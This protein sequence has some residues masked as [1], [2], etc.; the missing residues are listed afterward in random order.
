MSHTASSSTA[1]LRIGSGIIVPIDILTNRG[2][3]SLI[4]KRVNTGNEMK[5][6]S[7]LLV[8]ISFIVPLAFDQVARPPIDYK[9][10]ILNQDQVYEINPKKNLFQ[11]EQTYTL[12]NAGSENTRKIVFGV[13]P[14]L[15][16]QAIILKNSEGGILPH[17]VVKTSASDFRLG[18]RF[19]VYELE[20][21]TDIAPRQVLNFHIQY[22]LNPDAV[23]ESPKYWGGLTVSRNASYAIWPATGNNVV[24]GLNYSSPFVIRIRYPEG[25]MTCAPGNRVS[26]EKNAE[27]LVDTYESKKP[28]IPTFSCA[29][30][31]KVERRSG[32]LSVEFFIYPH[33]TLPEEMAGFLF[34]AVDLFSK[35]FGDN[36]THDFRVATAGPYNSGFPNAENKGNC[37]FMMDCMLRD[38]LKTPEGKL[39]YLSILFHEI[40]HDWNLFS[41]DWRGDYEEWFGE[42]GATFIQAW[43]AEIILGQDAARSVRR[44]T[45]NDF[46]ARKGFRAQTALAKAQ[47]TSAA[48]RALIYSYGALVWEQL[49]QKLGDDVFF[50]GFS[51]FIKKNLFKEAGWPD[52]LRCWKTYTKINIREY[53]VPWIDHNAQIS[54]AL[55]KVETLAKSGRYDTEVIINVDSDQDYEI[56]T[57]LEYKIE[58]DEK[59]IS[60]PLRF[61]KKGVQTVRFASDKAPLS[62][63]LDPDYRVPRMTDDRLTWEGELF[64]L[65]TERLNEH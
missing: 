11:S 35:H 54:L 51:D 5:K 4:R 49:R 37:V 30:Y 27:Y 42:G 22:S 43:A 65:A 41:L 17:K 10:R 13:H 56:L 58:K 32:K 29:P 46:I 19:E 21:E 14:Q 57:S 28:N 64:P 6:L 7:L 3:P 40:F 36:G 53:L 24:F 61:I 8:S 62:M 48:E 31:K 60:I 52:L 44:K 55:D 45:L 59:A 38:A 47:K 34:S 18:S 26:T 50:A 1:V 2:L 63:I 39:T 9:F 12:E 20:T 33:E 25:T 15:Q 23:T 16:I